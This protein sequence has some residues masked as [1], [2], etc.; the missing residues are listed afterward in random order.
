MISVS[1]SKTKGVDAITFDDKDTFQSIL[2]NAVKVPGIVDV[3]DPEFYLEVVYD[4]ENHQSLYLW[5]GEKR[6]SSSLMNTED[7]HTNK[8]MMAKIGIR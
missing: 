3:T 6:Q 1:V 2:A 5:I 8:K 4:N 7:T